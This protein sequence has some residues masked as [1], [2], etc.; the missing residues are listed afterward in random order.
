VSIGCFAAGLVKLGVGLLAL[1]KTVYSDL[2]TMTFESSSALNI[3]GATTAA[4]LT[5]V[6]RAGLA[7]TGNIDGRVTALADEAR[8]THTRAGCDASAAALT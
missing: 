7:G 4:F 2:R 1:A 8:G 6:G 3:V 5:E